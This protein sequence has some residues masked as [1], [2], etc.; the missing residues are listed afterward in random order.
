MSQITKRLGVWHHVEVWS[1][2]L[3]DRDPRIDIVI[4][5]GE[6]RYALMTILMADGTSMDPRPQ[7]TC[8]GAAPLLTAPLCLY[9]KHANARTTPGRDVC[10]LTCA[11][12]N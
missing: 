6:L 9:S 2:F 4:R 3:V 7:C 8:E 5:V 11:A 1:L 12:L 10:P